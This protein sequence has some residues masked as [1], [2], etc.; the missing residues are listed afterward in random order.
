MTRVSSTSLAMP[1][2]AAPDGLVKQGPPASDEVNAVP[3][4]GESV[5]ALADPADIAAKAGNPA[6]HP[7]RGYS[8]AEGDFYT[9]PRWT[10]ELLI[11]AENYSGRVWDPA[12]GHRTIERAFAARNYPIISSDVA[13]RPN[14]AQIDFL[15]VRPGH[16]DTVDHI[17]CN[18]PYSLTAEFVETALLHVRSSAAFLVPLKWLASQARFDLFER[19]GAP[20]RVHVLSNRPSMPPGA[21]IDPETGLFN[22]DDPAPRELAD[23]TLKLKWRKGDKPANGAIDYCWVVFVPG[24]GG[25]SRICWL[26]R[27]DA[28]SRPSNRQTTV[29]AAEAALSRKLEGLQ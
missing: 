27:A 23:G 19:I 2:N 14:A 12:C 3:G 5:A 9:E 16:I 13:R 7:N 21:F 11:E 18:P 25:P 17:V 20:A 28:V 29:S 1:T 15:K 10:V 26:A 24:Y 22:C 8:R 6:P 4:A